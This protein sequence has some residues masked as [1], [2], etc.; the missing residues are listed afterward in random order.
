MRTNQLLKV[1]CIQFIGLVNH[2]SVCVRYYLYSGMK[3]HAVAQLVVAL[4]YN[5]ESHGFE[6]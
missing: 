2:W 1:K 5:P 6:S 3:G 4:R